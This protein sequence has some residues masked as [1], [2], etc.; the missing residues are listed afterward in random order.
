MSTNPPEK[1]VRIVIEEGSF[2]DHVV[3]IY[4]VLDRF[5]KVDYWIVALTGIL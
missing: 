2:I 3:L 5:L 4:R 1:R